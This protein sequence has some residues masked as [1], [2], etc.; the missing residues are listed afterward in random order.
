MQTLSIFL[1]LEVTRG[2]SMCEYV[3]ACAYEKERERN[4]GFRKYIFS[5]IGITLS[6][7]THRMPPPRC[8][9]LNAFCPKCIPVFSPGITSFS[10]CHDR[11]A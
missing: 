1:T 6:L 5:G 10:Q 4:G 9:K 8:G 7:Y 2:E 11:H 3:R